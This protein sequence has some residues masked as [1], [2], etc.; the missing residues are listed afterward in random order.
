MRCEEEKAEFVF[1]LLEVNVMLAT[2]ACE[3]REVVSRSLRDWEL[4]CQADGLHE[5]RKNY[6]EVRG[7]FQDGEPLSRRE[8]FD[9]NNRVRAEWIKW[10]YNKL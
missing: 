2:L 10:I 3:K 9:E 5:S 1:F 8:F 4:F 7:S 6:E